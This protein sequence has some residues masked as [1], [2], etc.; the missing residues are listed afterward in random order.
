MLMHFTTAKSLNDDFLKSI[1]NVFIPSGFDTN[2]SSK[3]YKKFR[4]LY[5]GAMKPIQNP[6]NLWSVLA[7]LIKSDEN[8]EKLVEIV[9]IGNINLVYITLKSLKRL[10]NDK[11]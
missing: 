11:L 7:D 4:I 5:A 8:F 1:I 6:K 3:P 10:K 9:L 2:L